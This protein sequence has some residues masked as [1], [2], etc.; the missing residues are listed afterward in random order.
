MTRPV[1]PSKAAADLAASVAAVEGSTERR[2]VV[3]IERDSGKAIKV[4]AAQ[5]G[6]SQRLYMMRLAA[7]D[8]VAIDPRDLVDR[9]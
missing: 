2:L 1:R 6:I 8:G 4:R 3:V 9:T 5:L 7:A